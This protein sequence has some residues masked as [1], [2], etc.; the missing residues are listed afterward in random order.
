MT[1][2][3]AGGR[4]GLEGLPSTHPLI[5]TMPGVYQDDDFLRRLL[6]GLDQ[7]VAPVL[8]T[9]DNLHAYFDPELAPRDFVRWL[10]G[11]LDVALREDWSDRRR[12]ALVARAVEL[13]RWEGTVRGLERLAGA[14]VE[15]EIHVEDT[16]GVVWSASPSGALPGDPD[17]HVRIRIRPAQ[18]RQVD[19]G[20]LRALLTDAV[21]AHVRVTVEVAT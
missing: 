8:S 5:R 16:G 18:A 3:T 2:A 1:A 9:L 6:E 17:A 15:G 12:R 21:P 19:A 4:R 11:W 13:Y 10:A 20:W 7:V 14:Y